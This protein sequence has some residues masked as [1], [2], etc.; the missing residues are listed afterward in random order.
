MVKNEQLA[1][2]PG[3]SSVSRFKCTFVTVQCVDCC[4]DTTKVFSLMW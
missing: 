1:I 2:V 4:S 3:L